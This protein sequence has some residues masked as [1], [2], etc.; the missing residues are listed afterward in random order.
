M[1][2][3]AKSGKQG[4][5]ARS[6]FYSIF[7]PSTHSTYA[8]ANFWDF[9]MHICCAIFFAIHCNALEQFVQSAQSVACTF[10]TDG[11]TALTQSLSQ[12]QNIKT[13]F[14]SEFQK[15]RI[16]ALTVVILGAKEARVLIVTLFATVPVNSLKGSYN[17]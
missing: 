9:N 8:T 5:Y 7:R 3:D 1:K 13:L 10:G 11:T 14:C 16:Y 4:K 6:I 15:F 12:T 17:F 2:A